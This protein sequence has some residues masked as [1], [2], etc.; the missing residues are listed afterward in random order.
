MVKIVLRQGPKRK[1]RP[2]GKQRGIPIMSKKKKG[3]SFRNNSRNSG[4]M[5]LEE[6]PNRVDELHIHLKREELELFMDSKVQITRY[7]DSIPTIWG[8]VTSIDG[9]IG[10]EAI[11]LT[12]AQV[13]D[14]KFNEYY[15]PVTAIKRLE[16]VTGQPMEDNFHQQVVS[17]LDQSL[18]TKARS[19]SS[20][21]MSQPSAQ[22]LLDGRRSGNL[23]RAS[24]H[25]RQQ[26]QEEDQTNM[27]TRT[28]IRSRSN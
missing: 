14:E 1:S 7:G 26:E 16:N 15:V 18:D 28:P 21:R 19:R 8:T 11:Q 22:S 27:S 20:S 17:R 4:D 23:S 25:N 12:S 24:S 6:E 5:N 2:K 10:L 3:D 9:E 13:H